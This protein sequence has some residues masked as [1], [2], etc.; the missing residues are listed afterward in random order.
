MPESHSSLS[1]DQVAAFIEL[2][3]HG[4]LR[5]AAETLF[6]TEQGVRNRLLALEEHLGTELYRK[7]RGRRRAT[8]LTSQGKKFLPHALAFM[9]QADQ[10]SS[11]FHTS[12]APREIHVVASQYLIA[13]VLIDA[14]RRFHEAFPNIRV[15]LSARSEAEI[16]QTLRDDPEIAFGVAAPYEASPELEYRHLFSMNWSL[17]APPG[18]AVL[19]RRKLTLAD[20]VPYPMIF[21]ERGSTG[22]QHV[23]EALRQQNLAADVELE[24]TNTDLIVRMVEAHLGIAVVPLLPSGVVT[25]GRVVVARPLGDQVRPIES[26]ILRRRGDTLLP[27]AEAFLRFIEA[28]WKRKAQ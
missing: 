1:C 9:Q 21:F 22:R 7:Q 13:Y 3:R 26:G 12:D 20:V 24:A 16:E 28:K 23:A 8:P 11:L 18:H 6:I 2:S 17:I 14:V 10:L 15:R 19:K 25:K 4:S 5:K 27:E